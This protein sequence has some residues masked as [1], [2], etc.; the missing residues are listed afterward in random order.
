LL[1]RTGAAAGEESRN[2]GG[3]D[4]TLALGDA[5]QRVGEDGDV[6]YAVLEQVARLE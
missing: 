1:E 4:H 2:D 3:V 5:M 6:G